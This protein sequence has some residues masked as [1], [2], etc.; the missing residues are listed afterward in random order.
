MQ[1]IDMGVRR[2]IVLDLARVGGYDGTGTIDLCKRLASTYPKVEIVAGG[3][4]RNV[5]D[6][7]RLQAGGVRAA[8]VAS[9]LHDGRLQPEDLVRWGERETQTPPTPQSARHS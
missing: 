3:G 7:Q 2:I 5:A 8:L 1:A 6:L 4:I 9:A